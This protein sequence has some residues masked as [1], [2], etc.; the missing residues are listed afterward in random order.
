VELDSRPDGRKRKQ[1]QAHRDG[2]QETQGEAMNQDEWIRRIK[3]N[4][5]RADLQHEFGGMQF[6][7]VIEGLLLAATELVDEKLAEFDKRTTGPV[8]IV[9][10]VPESYSRDQIEELA[11]RMDPKTLGCNSVIVLPTIEVTHIKVEQLIPTMT[12]EALESLLEKVKR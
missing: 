1:P 10:K 7:R 12:Q 9:V 8:I 11:K 6:E 4:M 2:L 5:G 3:R